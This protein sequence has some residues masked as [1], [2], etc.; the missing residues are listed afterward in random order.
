VVDKPYVSP[1]R[2]VQHA[3][4]AAHQRDE[5]ARVGVSAFPFKATTSSKYA[6]ES[7]SLV[8]QLGIR[9]SGIETHPDPDSL[10]ISIGQALH[11]LPSQAWPWLEK[12]GKKLHFKVTP[13]GL[14]PY[15]WDSGVMAAGYYEGGPNRITVGAPS[16]KGSYRRHEFTT[17]N[18]TVTSARE[19]TQGMVRDVITHEFAHWLDGETMKISR[20]HPDLF[21]RNRNPNAPHEKRQW[22]RFAGAVSQYLASP[23]QREMLD[24]NVAKFLDR[25]LGPHLNVDSGG[26]RKSRTGGNAKLVLRVAAI[27]AAHE[28][29]M[30]YGTPDEVERKIVSFEK[31]LLGSV[32]MRKK[33]SFEGGL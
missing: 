7:K 27:R 12:H 3:D 11:R 19:S 15:R 29:R 5:A 23:G 30:L 16:S 6:I 24:P 18:G 4:Y 9:I 10:Y 20:K 22:E 21:G 17:P 2:K 25:Y 28:N 13:D 1:V 33:V 32:R 31:M 8:D 14:V 26:M